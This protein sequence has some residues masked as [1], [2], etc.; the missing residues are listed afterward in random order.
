MS[1]SP[2]IFA[3]A[4]YLAFAPAAW[5]QVSWTKVLDQSQTQYADE[6][7]YRMKFSGAAYGNGVFVAG[8]TYNG[9]MLW[10]S[11]DGQNW[12]QTADYNDLKI[13]DFRHTVRDVEF[14]GGQFVALAG[15]YSQ[16]RSTLW[17]SS[18]GADWTPVTTSNF[19]SGVRSIA[20]GPN[21]Y[22]GTSDIY[23][24]VGDSDSIAI[25]SDLQYWSNV[26]PPVTAIWEDVV[27][28]NG[29][30]V[31]VGWSGSTAYMITSTDGTHWT[32]LTPQDAN[33]TSIACKNAINYV[34]NRF[35]A[36]TEGSRIITSTDGQNW[37]DV[38]DPTGYAGTAPLNDLVYANGR[39]VWAVGRYSDASGFSWARVRASQ[40]L[41]G[42]W[43]KILD[44]TWYTS[45]HG[46]AV[47]PNGLIVTGDS[48][49]I[50][51]ATFSTANE[52][53][54]LNK[55]INMTQNQEMSP[56]QVTVSG[57]NTLTQSLIN[58]AGDLQSY[59]NPPGLSDYQGELTGTPTETGSWTLYA[60]AKDGTT[61]IIDQ[62][63]VTVSA[64]SDNDDNDPGGNDT[65]GG[66]PVITSSLSLNVQTGQYTEYQITST[67][68]DGALYGYD[69]Y[70]VMR[71]HD[72][73]SM[74][75]D[76]QTGHMTFTINRAGTYE[77]TIE[78]NN[79]EGSD[80]K[81]LTITASDDSPNTYYLNDG[82]VAFDGDWYWSEWFGLFYMSQRDWVYHDKF[83]WV[84]ANLTGNTKEGAW[85][86]MYTPN[87]WMWL[88]E[89]LGYG[90]AYS[91]SN[92]S[93][94][95]WDS[96]T[97]RWWAY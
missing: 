40:D 35:V 41:A 30:F 9:G 2:L 37:T 80:S 6:T 56:W 78:V 5:A 69:G 12:S 70:D 87:S 77:V 96:A 3:S 18:S 26:T 29:R 82:A 34:N 94:V 42:Y 75:F 90:I 76:M 7:N 53:T 58:G 14:Y 91:A 73:N 43:S 54:L 11:T 21:A 32:Q 72:E 1:Y 48:G 28:G 95:F 36:T 13:D 62:V 85:V 4:I 10:M 52:P 55:N 17:T 59:E 49:S 33:G 71:F 45:M 93:M 20:Y 74:T 25:S 66:A 8:G 15:N 86:Y 60:G 23:V 51:Y 81:I 63:T 79:T 44:E 64:A 89:Y 22:N 68:S 67:N 38:S 50:Y 31:A 65:P 46:A 57:M 39:Y 47:G 27:Y 97:G 84:F 88:S 92:D 61:S 83:G 16:G 24:A 19:P